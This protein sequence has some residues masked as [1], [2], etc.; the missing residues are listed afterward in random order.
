[1]WL[2]LAFLI[3]PLV[4]IA[5]FIEVGGLIGL[6]PTLAI[7]VVTAALGTIMV[8]QQGTATIAALRRA[9]DDFRDP[10]GPIVHGIM[11]LFAGALLL[12]PG[13][14]TDAVG[15]TLLVPKVREVAFRELRKRIDVRTVR[16]GRPEPRERPDRADVIDAEFR[17]IPDAKK[18]TH[19]PSGWTQH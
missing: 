2:F 15:F 8:R 14:F 11:I 7:V 16:G 12:T 3:V 19:Q 17:D 13:F 10:S 1:M 6:W 18:P 5:L 9:L 4:E